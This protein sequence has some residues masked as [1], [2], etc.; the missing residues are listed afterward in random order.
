MKRFSFI[1]YIIAAV[2]FFSCNK[3]N[4][5]IDV[6]KQW[7]ID[8]NGNLV[9]GLNDSQWQPGD[10]NS[11]ELALFNKL[12]TTNLSGTTKPDSVVSSSTIFP[13]PFRS[14]AAF[15]F[16]FSSGFNGQIVFKFVI[17]NDRMDI[18]DQGVARIQATSYPNIPMNPSTSG[19]V[20]INPNVPV[21][22]YR[23]YFTLSA[24]GNEHFFKTWGNIEKTQ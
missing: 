23:I 9:Q 8:V 1:V 15:V 21:G 24:Q 10:F 3:S 20:M 14:V 7:T 19:A 18:V 13:N 22:K 17:V 2:S 6:S 11:S 5:Q 12:D 16:S 4:N